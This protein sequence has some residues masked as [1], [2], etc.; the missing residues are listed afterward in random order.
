[1]SVFEIILLALAVGL[2]LVFFGAFFYVRVSEPIVTRDGLRYIS[3]EN[4]HYEWNKRVKR[5]Q[6]TLKPLALH[7]TA[8]AAVVVWVIIRVVISFQ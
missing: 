3:D 4:A 5:L 1:M 6:K 7:I 2:E 8:L